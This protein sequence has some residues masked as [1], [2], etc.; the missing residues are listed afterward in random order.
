MPGRRR[1]QSGRGVQVHPDF[2][3]R[4]ALARF[5]FFGAP[6]GGGLRVGDYIDPLRVRR[7]LGAVVVVPVPP[8]VRRGLGI[9][10]WRVLPSFLAAERRDVEVAPGTAHRLIGTVVNEVCA[11]YSVAV[12]KEDVVAVPFVDAEVLIEAVGDGVPGHIPFHPRLEARD[13]RLRA[14]G[15]VRGGG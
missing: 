10:L 13:L 14:A 8:F 3:W 9:T 2:K 5:L 7:D 1:E 15:G 12:V 11:E 6:S 4:L